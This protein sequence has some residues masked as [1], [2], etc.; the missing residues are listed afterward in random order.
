M[1]ITAHRM[2]ADCY[3]KPFWKGGF[4]SIFSVYG[5]HDHTIKNL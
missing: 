4:S 5:S 2:G 3:F 1:E